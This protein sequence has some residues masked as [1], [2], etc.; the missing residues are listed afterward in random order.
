MGRAPICETARRIIVKA[1]LTIVGE[2]ILDAA[3]CSQLCAGQPSGT[4]AA[5]HAVRLAFREDDAEA[6]LMVDASNAFNALNRECAL[7]NIQRVCPPLATILINTYREPSELFVDGNIIWSQ[8]GTTQGD[9]LAMAMYALATISLVY[10]LKSEILQVCY[11]DDASA[12]GKSLPYA[13]GGTG[14]HPLAP[15]MVILQTHPRH[16][17]SPN[18][19]I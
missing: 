8:E 11:A 13:I 1:V 18:N 3:R 5:V 16:G 2:H 6:I 12:V 17:S 7:H 9:P 19:S 4:E 15:P 10:S 14:F